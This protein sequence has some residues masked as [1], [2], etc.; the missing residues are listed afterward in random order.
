MKQEIIFDLET[1]KMF[2]EN[3][4]FE[5]ANLGVSVVS[6]YSRRVAD[7]GREAGGE[8]LSFWEKDFDRMWKYFLEADRIVG[9]NSLGF[10]VPALSRYAPSQFAK[11]PHFDI[12]FQI[13]GV[14]GHRTSLHKLAKATLGRQKIDTGENATIYWQRGDPDSLERLKK[15]CEMDVE[16]TKEIYDYGIAHKL[17]KFTDYWNNPR[18]VGVDFSYPSETV[19]S[20]QASLF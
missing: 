6:L 2:D 16:L 10:D 12:L 7:D 20:V 1:K 3:G 11:L 17:L 13:R 9:F 18:E 15:Y 19:S 14:T 5:P 4:K 8:M